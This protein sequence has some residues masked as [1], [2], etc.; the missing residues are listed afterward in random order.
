MG[1]V[2]EVLA[3][4]IWGHAEFHA[5]QAQLGGAWLQRE[6][7][8]DPTLM[9]SDQDLLRCLQA[10]TVLALSRNPER[11]KAAYGIAACAAGLNREDLPGLAGVLRIVLTRLGNFPALASSPHV[12]TFRR[13]PLL[14]ALAEEVR[15]DGNRISLG[16]LAID[17]TDFQRD[18]WRQLD[19]GANVSVSAPTSAGKSFVLQAYLRGLARSGKLSVACYIVPSRA[20]IAQVTDAVT[21]WRRSD[22]LKGFQ[23]VNVPLPAETRLPQRAIY[24]LTQERLQAIIGAHPDFTADIV[25]S[26]EAQ[27]IED[28]SRGVLLQ[29]VIDHLI[30]KRPRAQFIFAGPNIRDP[31]VFGQIFELADLKPVTTRS[32]AVLQNLI[33]VRTRSPLQRLVL[34]RLAGDGRQR[35]GEVELGIPLPS[36]KERLVRVAE[37]FGGLK[38]SIVYSNGPANAESVALGLEEISGADKV[39]RPRI[40]ELVELVKVAVHER[41]DLVR[42][43]KRRVG[44]HYGRIP[45]IVR[46]GIETAFADGDLR[47]LVT[48]STLIQGVNFPAANLFV[49]K[50]R[51]GTAGPL[52]SAEFWNLAGRAGRLGR[53]FQ[54]N[55]FLIDYDDWDTKPADEGDEVDVQSALR[56][57]LASKLEDIVDCALETTPKL[58]RAGII[59]I[60]A[61][62]SRLLSDFNAGRLGTTL[63]KCGVDQA[64]RGRLVAALEKA[65]KR[66]TLP[67]SVLAK[68]PTV[69]PL[70]Q[71]R[72]AAYLEAEVKGGGV[73]RLEELLPRHPRDDDAWNSLSEVFRVCHEELMSLQVPRLHLRM[74]AI[75]L[76]WMQG[77]QL[78]AI[79]DENHRRQPTQTLPV[80]IRG[81]LKD[82]EEEIRFKYFRLTLCYLAVFEHVL[83]QVGFAD[84]VKS[85]PPLPSFLEVGASDPTMISFVGLGISRSVASF[86][87]DRTINKRMDEA[88]AL[89]WLV[90]QDLDALLGSGLMRADVQR[91]LANALIA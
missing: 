68:S 1:D 10:A 15:R 80:V 91:A 43:L 37:R 57:T 21:A 56:R 67:A 63:D 13:L 16:D 7:G 79:I 54:G 61:T 45:A 58:E 48:T 52:G 39:E 25:I 62:F 33:V 4:R 5:R 60:E 26:D 84:Y 30:A 83:V 88:Q 75:A 47:Y 82:I 22:D 78:P 72:L 89:A 12:E 23:I 14:A 9:I 46:R 27:S 70:R 81:T 28:G 35:L 38:P 8:I 6:L 90:D 65:R 51:K 18:L 49:C 59:D 87:T 53:E 64:A 36:I 44:F 17:L 2:I 66:I 77:K 32:P 3:D 74:A 71:Q 73:A 34:E 86:L 85:L 40:S 41:Y 19:Q 20:L 24:V 42:C 11:Q 31:K 55:V 29:G 69:S 76:K 50:P